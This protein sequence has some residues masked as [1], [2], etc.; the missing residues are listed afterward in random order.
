M[1]ETKVPEVK[2]ENPAIKKFKKTKMALNGI[3]GLASFATIIVQILTFIRDL[4]NHLQIVANLANVEM[5]K[6]DVENLNLI[7]DQKR[8]DTIVTIALALGFLAALSKFVLMFLSGDIKYG[9][10]IK[11]FLGLS[12]IINLLNI[13]LIV[14]SKKEE[15]KTKEE[16]TAYMT[17]KFIFTLL[18]VVASFFTLYHKCFN[19]DG[20]GLNWMGSTNFKVLEMIKKMIKTKPALVIGG[21]IGFISLTVLTVILILMKT[22]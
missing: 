17:T 19:G 3:L 10:Q 8:L 14:F 22:S 4:N 7:A 11:I 15:E 6:V 9:T 5:E 1:T 12:F 13:L 16:K 20:E 18:S 2:P 21:G